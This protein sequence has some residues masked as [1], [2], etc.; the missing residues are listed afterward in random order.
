VI[1]RPRH[2]GVLSGALV[3][4]ALPALAQP[5][6]YR[7]IGEM[8]LKLLGVNATVDPLHP[9]IPKN[10]PAAV[11]IVVK[12]GGAELPLADTIRFLGPD[13]K[14]RGD[15]S[16]PGLR[17]ALSLPVETAGD[18][19]PADPLLL[20]LPVLTVSGNYTLANLRIE[21]AGRPVLDVT[22]QSVTV[23]VIEQVLVTSVK[24]RSLTLDEIREKGIVLDSDDYLGFE[25]TLGLKLESQP[26]TLSFPVVFDRQGV[27][28]PDP[29]TP[30]AAPSRQGVPMP[31]VVP[32]LLE[33]V[34]DVGGAGDGGGERL[35]LTLPSGQPIRIPAVLV[36]PGNVGYLKQFFSAQL[37]VANGAPVG[38]GLR[39]R[40]V[41]GTIK[42]PP[43]ADHELG[44]N[45][46]PLTLPETVRGPQPATLPLL[47]VGPDGQPGTEDDADRFAPGEQGQAEFLLRGEREGFHSLDFDI[48]AVLEGLASGPVTIKGKA[49]G[50][51]LVRNPF[52]DM[53]FTVPS[54]VRR[55]ERFKLYASVTNIGQGIANDVTVSLDA[56]ALA[57][58]QLV[59]DQTV[60]ID[61]L[62]TGDS[63]TVAFELESQ[64]T[65]QVVASYLKLDGPGQSGGTLRF[66]L[67]VG[68]RGV[69]LSPDT[70]V[71]PASVDDVPAAVLDAAMRVLGQA[72]SLANAPSG[73]LPRGV[74]RT[75]KAVVVAKALAL[76]EAGLRISLGQDVAG[77]I[78]ALDYDMFA[79]APRDPGFDQL[80]RD[81][82][83]GQALRQVFGGAAPTEEPVTSGGPRL[84]AAS[85][86]GPEVLAG[87]GPFGLHGI[88]VFDR[89]LDGPSA[90][91][92]TRYV[93]PNNA[94]RSAKA[95]LSG[96]LVVVNLSQPE[97]PYVQTTIEVDGL[98]DLRGR[99][100]G[101]SAEFGS[102]LVDP[103]AVVTGR[104]LGADG[105][106]VRTA[107]V[108]HTNNTDFTCRFP[109]QTG[110]ASL[111][112]D[113][114]GRFEYRYV[115]R[116]NC[117]QPFEM[118][119]QDPG[120]GAVRKSSGFVRAAGERIVLDIVL[121]G[122]GSVEGIVRDLASQPVAGAKVVALSASDP[123]SGGQAV[124]DGLGHYRIDGITVG[125]LSVKAAKGIALGRA[126]G[127]I[128]RAGTVA[129]VDVVLDGGSARVSG[130]VRRVDGGVEAPVPGVGVVYRIDPAPI[131]TP[132]GYVKTG[133]DGR[134]QFEAMPAGQVQLTTTLD[135]GETAQTPLFTVAAGDDLQGKDL[136]VVAQT[137]AES[138]SV[139]GVVL[140]PEGVPAAQALVSVGPRGT[141]TAD[142]GSFRLTGIEVKPGQSQSL[143]ATSSDRKRVG[144]TTFLLNQ[145]GQTV[146]IALTL[147]GLGTARFTVLD[148][149]GLPLVG[150]EVRVLSSTCL[151]PCGCSARTAGAD[152]TVSY[153]GVPLGSVSVQ[154]VRDMGSGYEA[155]VA[156]A[157]VTRD[158]ETGSGVLRFSG[159]GVVSGF[160]MDPDGRPAFGADVDMVSRHFL[161]DGFFCGMVTSPSHHGRTGTD[162]RVRFT[163]V[164][165]GPVSLSARQDF[166][167]TPA[168]AVGNLTSGS[169]ELSFTLQLKNTTA[170]VLS[171]TVFL[172]DG[173][174]PAGRG[175]AVTATGGLPEVVVE[176]NDQGQFRFARIFPEGA[177]R[178]TLNDP[179]AGGK[180]EARVYLR[181][182]QDLA[183]D[184]RLKGR[185]TVRVT[186]V[187]GADQPVTTAY[188][189]LHEAEFPSRAYESA[190]AAGEP[191]VA[192][193]E[194]V[195][196]GPYS[197]E[198][199]DVF[200]RGGR[201]SGTMPRA[202]EVVDIKVRLTSTGTV[203]GHF[204]L[205]DGLTT[206]PYGVVKLTANGRAIGQ[207]TTAG[208]GDVGGFSF[209]YVPAGP[210]RLDAEDP[211]T[212]RTGV[213][214]GE[215]ESDGQTLE[216]DVQ[217]QALGA[218]EGVVT[219]NG[220]PQAA[221]N[222]EVVSGAYRAATLA[223]G[224]GRYLV[225]GVPAGRVVATA[226]LS[227]GFLQGTAS[228]NLDGEGSSLSLDVALRGS[229]RVTGQVLAADGVTPAS[230]SVVRLSVGGA[231]GGS[232]TTLTQAEGRFVFDRVPAG[233]ATL[234]ADVVS[235]I[236]AGQAQV[237]VP[238][239]GAVDVPIRL[240]GI[241][242]LRGTAL[243][244]SGLPTAG[245]VTVTVTG[246]PP[247]SLVVGNDGRFEWP[248]VAAGS[249]SANL[250]VTSPGFN[251]FGSASG[252]VR[253]GEVT[254]FSIQVQPSGTVT[255]IV[256]RPDAT[257]PAYGAQV[258]VRLTSGP[259]V[260][261]Q[262]QA[263]GRF[264]ARGVPL[265]AL[266]VSASDPVTAGLA[267]LRGRSLTANGETLDV[268]TLVLDA[269]PPSLAPVAPA[270]GSVRA[271]FGGPLLLDVADDG[272]VDLSSLTIVEPYLGA[273][274]PFVL[275]AGRATSTLRPEA[276]VVGE[277][278]FVAQ[279]K[280]LSGNLTTAEWR[281]TVTGGTLR[282]TVLRADGTPAPSAPIQ[283]DTVARAPSDA[284]GGFVITGLRPGSHTLSATDPETGLS[285]SVFLTLG[286]GEDLAMAEPLRLPAFG[287]IVGT[288]RRS[289]GTPAS[290]V[291]VSVLFRPGSVTTGP[292]GRFD[293]GALPLGS[294]TLNAAAADGD[295][296]QALV[297]LTTLGVTV[298]TNLGLNGIGLVRVTLRDG[299][300]ALVG[301]AHVT[302]TSSSALAS[303]LTG[304]TASDG[305]A[306]VFPSALAGTITA[307]ATHPTNGLQ[308]ET[309][310]LLAVGGILDLSATLQPTGRIAGTVFRREGGVAGAVE[311][312][313]S[314]P[315]AQTVVAGADGRFA[316]EDVPLGNWSL[317]VSD[318]T[319]GDQ[320]QAN[321]IL[322]TA[323]ATANGDV[324]LNGVGTVRVIVRDA[325]GAL[326][327]GAS[328]SVTSSAGR[329][330]SAVT[331]AAGLATVPQVLAGSITATAVHPANGTRGTTTGTLAAAGQ[332]D[333]AVALQATGT[334]RGH[335]LAPDGLSPVAGAS[336]ASGFATITS[337]ADGLFEFDDAPLG[338]HTLQ[339][340][341]AG[342]LRARAAASLTTNGQVVEQDL[343]LVGAAPVR[344]RVTTEAGAPVSGAQ[345]SLHSLAA[346]Y[347]GVFAAT[348]DAVGNYEVLS[349]PLG[350]FDV[351]AAKAAD[352]A[353]A[354]GSVTSDAVPV[355]VD[356][357]LLPSVV[358]LPLSLVD[359]NG[360]QWQVAR[361]GTLNHGATFKGPE[362]SSR[363]TIVRG[364]V[365]TTF[366]G[367]DC[368]PTCT[369]ATEEGKR[370]VV[371]PQGGVGGLEVTRKVYIAPDAY[372]ARHLDVVLNPGPDPVTVD[373][374]FT[375][376]LLPSSLLATS[377][378][379]LAY[380]AD[381]RWITVDDA[382][383]ADP[384]DGPFSANSSFWPLGIVTSG[385]GGQGPTAAMVTT[386][387]DGSRTLTETWGSVTLGPGESFGLL[388]F[389]TPQVDRA[390]AQAA[391][392]RLVQLPPEALVGL[393]PSEGLAV[394]NFVVPEG[395]ASEVMPLPPNDG[396]V[397]GRVLAGDAQTPAGARTVAFRSRSP[398]FGRP[399]FVGSNAATGAYEVRGA[400]L[401]STLVPRMPF[402]LASSA[403]VL[404][405]TRTASA[406]GDFP[407]DGAGLPAA[408]TTLDLA[409]R[410]T[411]VLDVA[412]SRADASPIAGVNLTLTDGTS[413]LFDTSD[414]AGLGQFVLLPPGTFSLKAA[415]PFGPEQTVS[416]TLLADQRVTLPLAFGDL[417]V[418]QGTL[419]TAAGQPIG[420]TVTIAAP[421]VFTRTVSAAAATGNYQLADVPFGSYTVQ[422]SDST[423]SGAVVTAPASV[424]GTPALVDLQLPPVGRVNVTVKVGSASGAPLATSGIRWKSDARGPD[425]VFA[426]FSNSIGQFSIP[427]VAGPQ[428]RIRADHPANGNSFGETSLTT[429]A[430]GQTLDVTVV[431][432]GVGT[433]A[434]TLRSRDG[435]PL[436]GQPVTA[437]AATAPTVLA[438]ATADALGLFS[439]ANVPVGSLRLSATC[440]TVYSAF[441]FFGRAEV[442]ATLPSNGA[443][444][445]QDAVCPIGS[446]SG[447]RRRDFWTFSA[448]AGAAIGLMLTPGASGAP[449]ADPYLEIYGP[450]GTLV[451]ANDDRAAGEKASEVAFVASAD[452]AYVVVA[453]A[454]A[455]QAG[456][457]RLGHFAVASLPAL[458]T[459]EPPRVAGV[460]RKD[461]DDAAVPGQAL[462]ILS[463]A[464][465][466]EATTTGADG[467]FSLGVFPLGAY[468]IEATDGEDVVVARTTGSAATPG[469]D[470]TQDVVL[471]A[472]GTVSVQVLRG[473][474]SLG[475]LAVA[476]ASTHA[477]A[478]DEDRLRTRTTAADGT[479]STTLPTG[480]VTARVTDPRNGAVYEVGDVLADGV[481]LAL[482]ID[483]PE[484]LTHLFGTVTA[485]DGTTPL[486][487]ALVSLAGP[488]AF[489]ATADAL[490]R[491]EFLSLP[492]GSYTL[493]AAIGGATGSATVSLNGGERPVDIQVPVP[494][495]KGQVTE[496]DGTTPAAATVTLCGGSPYSC[497]AQT[498][499]AAGLYVFYGGFPAW[500][501]GTFVSAQITAADGSGL[502]GFDAFPFNTGV[503]TRNFA[504]PAA[505]AVFGVVRDAPG[506]TVAAEV[507]LRSQGRERI[508]V[509][510]VDGAFR[511]P[512]VAIPA[513]VVVRAADL[514]YGLPGFAEG[515]IASADLQLD[516]T[517][518]PGAAFAGQLQ[519]MAGA[520][521]QG[522]IQLE[523]LP[524]LAIDGYSR[525]KALIATDEVGHFSTLVPAGGY[526][527]VH[528]SGSCS[529]GAP[530]RLLLAAA[531]GTLFAGSNPE[532]T[533]RVG[534]GTAYP[535]VLGGALGTYG[536]SAEHPL[537]DT[538]CAT[539]GDVTLTALV[540]G[541]PSP[542]T[543]GHLSPSGQNVTSLLSQTSGLDVRQ[544]Q[545][546]PPSGA[547][548]RT[549][550]WLQNPGDIDVA[551]DVE[552]T[553]DFGDGLN[554]QVTGASSGGS[555][556]NAG[557]TWV[558]ARHEDSSSEAGAAWGTGAGSVYFQRGSRGD[559]VVRAGVVATFSVVVPAGQRL[560]LMAFA[561]GRSEGLGVPGQVRSL[562]ELSDPEALDGLSETD[563]QEIV[564]FTVPATPNPATGVEGTLTRDGLPSVSA[565]VAAFDPA[566]GRVLAYGVTDASG[567]FVLRGLPAGDVRLVAVDPATNRPGSNT[568]TVADGL[569]TTA[570]IAAIPAAE[571]GTIQG[572]VSNFSAEPV[573]GAHVN[574]TSDDFA[575]LWKAA[576]TTGPAGEYAMAAPPG[577]IH[578]TANDDPSTEAI[579]TLD[580][581]ATVV[582]DLTVP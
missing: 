256:L 382:N 226:S 524:Y 333:L 571:M 303:P 181:A 64:K 243:D 213:A 185:G 227:G 394:R 103:G 108:V 57:G 581:G 453:R 444:L 128:D 332:L 390:R 395:L 104:V 501:N 313:L 209:D 380:G 371:L 60:H 169:Q 168:T 231:G 430:E 361:D 493:S 284:S 291:T 458:R 56:A 538:A 10:I 129:S 54:V 378:G 464:A 36:I 341:V 360:Y 561:V 272:G 580:P 135:T 358:N 50:G 426:G 479:V 319:T 215:I 163:G 138:G 170:G 277:N 82:E 99:R 122:R 525:W 187:D 8:E 335:V 468:T 241:G 462:R 48:A 268:G 318:A 91:V 93:V 201:A 158:G 550:T 536:P 235:S 165:V 328:V 87:A 289:D 55:G 199:S 97:G 540:A 379:D 40:N 302:V 159:L 43:G 557:V 437:L 261:V 326:V 180:A 442:A 376:H 222:V 242:V 448:T 331:D 176:T 1:G 285:A 575:P 186:V 266:T 551:T 208:S 119:T 506:A 29:L 391:A 240:R 46:D 136:L 251:L 363:L 527:A 316:F 92:A 404:G 34:N 512:H 20:S 431:V 249:F 569:L 388:R 518:A 554:W 13:L 429:I 532:V 499:D 413:S 307:R 552:V 407:P 155:V 406:S 432:P 120:T 457:Y 324:T 228:G 568:A 124:T 63:K 567:R 211:L 414:A 223:D 35:P 156:N 250:R 21:S 127:R 336:V 535:S 472:R 162:G 386:E 94:V 295:R 41:T 151:D 237:V 417:G 470:V 401:S 273:L 539:A 348:T 194:G 545:F 519:D 398:Y 411:G 320:G 420:G 481:S 59:S 217:A 271:A 115:R 548:L 526:R 467:A 473:V 17:E 45:D 497:V 384:Y 402:D 210:V 553:A 198:A 311:V 253:P 232:L 264:T 556:V 370:E 487:G 134:F 491:Y 117:G 352:R 565:P 482:V 327:P 355:T 121:L 492:P 25:F 346:I 90:A 409:Y 520:P 477:G 233:Q 109:G 498:S 329:G 137:A 280:D 424:S 86:I 362:T 197:V 484:S 456:A 164:G 30:P 534:D 78:E 461:S 510:D 28:I 460:V 183:Q 480:P 219:S 306:A 421:G 146:Q 509:T 530:T 255:G 6:A 265:G 245:F 70:L 143:S 193:I 469:L 27:A 541:D 495:L 342:R 258:T 85:I 523:S 72:W 347:G 26:V 450:D 412:V 144:K 305:G 130:T 566:D 286:D 118:V 113:G 351:S 288:V 399:L 293:L 195:Y 359:G 49:S 140:L 142:D 508:L 105:T 582:I 340:T 84:V 338:S 579:S 299:A 38:S 349:V 236:D 98:L 292:D 203:R 514:Q 531:D 182:G 546:V 485:A 511:F 149:A 403:V 96:R 51:V 74:V 573:A 100:G 53:T 190:V 304:T 259:Q 262:A 160:V 383:A 521:L 314:Q 436:G 157:S 282:G 522:E 415:F 247:L 114:D 397:T 433:I 171:G 9:V 393:S 230:L 475:G 283:L 150:Q 405:G 11:R 175:V 65:G 172:P 269:R 184:V 166:Y 2:V 563:L 309:T 533:L 296:G 366:A 344:G 490:G 471:P 214:V 267:L 133:A 19:P 7:K 89:I 323:G 224:T 427:Y 287:R 301:G 408:S 474:E 33:A 116:D 229:G 270:P 152:G 66:A 44:T 418:V 504:L 206:I 73:T 188:V 67:G 95:A 32:L 439:L 312:R 62:R 387:G 178:L 153:D 191:G 375:T 478:L 337:A 455:A 200:A 37:F 513:N 528:D 368:T 239:G 564:N 139:E 177:Y 543:A 14:V 364:G 192:T 451:A 281:F 263:D 88:L 308:G 447:V 61:T 549:I 441:H 392:E 47:G 15:L 111:P 79:G 434:G 416:A 12:A 410:G 446:I 443:T 145:A 494:V 322:A 297:T 373:L 489:S 244:S 202:G 212:G 367:P 300:G 449:L 577:T 112:V 381:D 572:A 225:R 353:S 334:I 560:G 343:V 126:A 16:G 503:T 123:Q 547:F 24:T 558:H 459:Y 274:V 22:P 52:F 260:T 365:A 562:A 423:R 290:A 317:T 555:S 220:D 310:G 3:A 77:S 476:L 246:A 422:A 452:G 419:R 500:P 173:V 101:G 132:V 385:V 161:Y 354:S 454:A 80:L 147:S 578:V 570:D 435:A 425:Y 486:P 69:P 125:P 189:K 372:F 321:G 279:V 350:A 110:I 517:L 106:A 576:A 276:V 42:L 196:E 5:I 505:A 18:P 76:A 167:P 315:R 257:N 400:P 83:A 278:R 252:E 574:A 238:S 131:A 542:T 39:L 23:E 559:G 275:D 502:T 330:Y 544:E 179:V 221:A 325:G 396:V 537:R 81:T 254:D 71:L 216:L 294:Y 154:A 466:R 174:T 248:E 339:A 440:D 529:A 445:A 377:S 218:V 298:D 58:A 428:F 357:T 374:T 463:G 488:F 102:R 369:A 507:R 483:L 107:N 234:D 207:I 389:E 205:P 148:P 345:I 516:V 75:S 68:E 31:T 204:L 465:P 438:S 515:D 496:A 356:L 141:L 4:L